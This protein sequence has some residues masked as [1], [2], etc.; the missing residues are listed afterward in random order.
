MS[1]RFY[2]GEINGMKDPTVKR[3]LMLKGLRDHQYSGSS[4][5][6]AAAVAAKAEQLKRAEES[7]RTVMYL[8]CW[9]PN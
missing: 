6:Q 7:L 9:G 8:S 2:K 1:R 5:N 3:E 4:S